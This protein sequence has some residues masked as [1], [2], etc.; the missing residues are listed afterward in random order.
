MS[1]V[2]S[3][4]EHVVVDYGQKL[5]EAITSADSVIS[6]SAQQLMINSDPKFYV[7]EQPGNLN[8]LSVDEYRPA[9]DGLPQ[10]RVIPV[11]SMNEDSVY[12]LVFYNSLGFQRQQLVHVLVDSANVKVSYKFSFRD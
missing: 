8:G 5:L 4:Q 1:N 11:K 7:E 12:P 6:T 3:I 10:R 9:H 2:V